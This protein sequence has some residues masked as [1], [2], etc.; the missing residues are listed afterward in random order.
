MISTVTDKKATFLI[1]PTAAIEIDFGTWFKPLS[2]AD[3][4]DFCQQHRDLRIERDSSG[5]IIVMAPTFSETGGRNFMLSV[6]FGIWVEQNGTGKGFDSSTGFTLPN[7]AIR[8]PDLSWIKL[9]RWEKIAKAKRK[10]F[11]PICPDFVVEL[12]SE[13]DSLKKLQAKMNEYIE[14]GASLGWLI[15]AIE[16]K[17]YI[18][19]PNTEPKILANPT[20]ISDEPLL[21]KFVLKLNEIW[22]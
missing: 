3:F 2:D 21:P 11:A 1:N 14:N 6:K 7:G 22:D 18:Y 13:S 8:S 5:E 16:R 4:Y 12:R 10:T 19:R 15:D 20:E 9:A 17:I